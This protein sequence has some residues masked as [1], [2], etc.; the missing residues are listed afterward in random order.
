MRPSNQSGASATGSGSAN[1]STSAIVAFGSS[2]RAPA[3]W[4]NTPRISAWVV[5]FMASCSQTQGKPARRQA[6]G[7]IGRRRGFAARRDQRCGGGAVEAVFE[8]L[9]GDEGP[10]GGSRHGFGNRRRIAPAE[11]QDGAVACRQ[12]GEY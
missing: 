8:C 10:L 1:D 9:T 7:E 3:I 12:A 2:R 6:L 11:Q 5:M 4:I